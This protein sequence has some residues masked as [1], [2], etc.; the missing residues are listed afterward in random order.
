[1]NNLVWITAKYG[2]QLADYKLHNLESGKIKK[3]K[4]EYCQS[5]RLYADSG[6]CRNCGAR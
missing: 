6:N 2:T 5:T 3:T 1:M 4:C